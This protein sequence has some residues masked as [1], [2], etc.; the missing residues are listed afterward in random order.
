[1]YKAKQFMIKKKNIK[2]NQRILE[3]G[4]SG[5]QLGDV[6]QATDY[7]LWLKYDKIT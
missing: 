1:M 3:D 2:Y 5:V 4:A 7:W 6:E